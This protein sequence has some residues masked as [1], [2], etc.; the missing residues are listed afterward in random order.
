MEQIEFR[1]TLPRK[2]LLFFAHAKQREHAQFCFI[3]ANMR[4]R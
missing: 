3:E 2:M 1:T 4:A